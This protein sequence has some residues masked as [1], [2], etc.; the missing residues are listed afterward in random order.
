MQTTDLFEAHQAAGA[1]MAP[2][3]GWQM[4]LH[5][6]SAM[7]EHQAVR[8]HAGMFDVSH[9]VL[10]DIQG[11]DAKAFCRHLFAN[12]IG[13]CEP[14][15]AQYTCM[16]NEKGGVIDDLIVYVLAPDH[17][18]VVLNA[19]SIE[20]DWPW[21]CQHAAGMAVRLSKR[22]VAMLAVQGPEALEKIAAC[23]P[24]PWGASLAGMK[25]FR[26]IKE[27]DWQ[28]ASTGYTGESGVEI[29][30]PANEIVALWQRCLDAG[31][32]PCG[33]AARDS[34]RLESG[35]CLYGQ[36]LDQDHSPLSSSLAWTIAWEPNDRNFIGRKA[37]E[38]ER[39]Q[40][41]REELLGLVLEGK[42]V[43]RSGQKVLT[44]NGSHGII[45]SGGYAPTLSRSIALMRCPA[46]IQI[47]ETV[48]V[49]M[50]GR[51]LPCRVVKPPFVKKGQSN[52]E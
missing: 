49:E 41:V 15:R 38:A 17:Y 24:E 30:A 31:I 20:T 46:D 7:A 29:M 43:L 27:G 28:V 9:M 5:Y 42:G 16:L 10:A 40:G 45:T 2:F 8:E 52:I 44:A 25:P 47:G 1:M 39:T 32:A 12:D 50:R 6:G 35:F 21:L 34:L 13:R 37:L 48:T 3:A 4:P 23:L 18:A 14:G 33:L 26:V 51:T 22:D 11:H 19:G 36:D